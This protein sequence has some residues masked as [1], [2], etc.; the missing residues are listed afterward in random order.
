MKESQR[1]E[2]QQPVFPQLQALSSLFLSRCLMISMMMNLPVSSTPFSNLHRLIML[3]NIRLNT[4]Q[5]KLAQGHEHVSC[6]LSHE[7]YVD[8]NWRRNCTKRS[9]PGPTLPPCSSVP[10]LMST[11]LRP[12]VSPSLPGDSLCRLSSVSRL[13]IVS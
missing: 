3:V 9:D 13:S 2:G 11:F 6:L 8:F 4:D 7:L 10:S 12:G 5:V 1:R